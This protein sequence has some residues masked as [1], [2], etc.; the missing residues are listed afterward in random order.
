MRTVD[1]MMDKHLGGPNPLRRLG[2]TADQ[3]R[4]LMARMDRNLRDSRCPLSSKED[5]VLQQ[6][7]MR[8]R[9]WATDLMEDG[10]LRPAEIGG[11]VRRLRR[12]GY[13]IKRER[14][15]I[16]GAFNRALYTWNDKQKENP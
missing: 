9:A 1:S 15:Q 6:I 13:P 10:N 2:L 3:V 12:A 4:G 16:G 14:I 7:R 5:W 8:G 11:I